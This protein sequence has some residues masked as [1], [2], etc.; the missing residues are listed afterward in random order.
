M[1]CRIVRD[2]ERIGF[3]EEFKWG[4]V[5]LGNCGNALLNALLDETGT[6]IGDVFLGVYVVFA[7]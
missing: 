4:V 3:G 6:F 5:F 7:L 2:C 1:R